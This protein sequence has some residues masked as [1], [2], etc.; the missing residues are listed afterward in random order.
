MRDVILE[1]ITPFAETFYPVQMRQL[2]VELDLGLEKSLKLW[3]AR[4]GS[5]SKPA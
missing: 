5:V 1:K 4:C 2:I 3:I